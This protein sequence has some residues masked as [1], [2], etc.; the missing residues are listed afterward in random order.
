MDVS[1]QDIELGG[2]ATTAAPRWQIA[3]IVAVGVLTGAGLLF[4]EQRL[5]G[6]D[7]TVPMTA[8]GIASLCYLAAAVTG[9]RWMSWAWAGFGTVLVFAAEVFDVQR[10]AV[11]ALAGAVLVVIG[12]VRRR[13]VTWPQTIAM[14]GY[15]GIAV[16]ALLLAP[17]VG[18]ALAGPAL[19]AH[20]V[21]DV[22][23]YRR[24]IVVSRS[25]ALWCI[26][27]DV[28]VGAVCITFAV[29]G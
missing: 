18:L 22:V 11:L 21:W 3:L 9:L 4:G 5:G 15:F 17:R 24:D 19:A 27:L 1:S 2:R 25:M 12:I 16:V 10:W 6:V 8:V 7:A 28:F 20:A 23:H 14:I 29:I 26:G 13:S